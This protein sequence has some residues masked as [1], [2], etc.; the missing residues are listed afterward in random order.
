EGYLDALW[1]KTPTERHDLL[2][3]RAVSERGAGDVHH[4][5][6]E[7]LKS[8]DCFGV[9]V[10][11]RSGRKSDVV[12]EVAAAVVVVADEGRAGRCLGHARNPIAVN[13][14]LDQAVDDDEAKSVVTDC[15]DKNA[16]GAHLR[17]LIDEDAGHPG[18]K[19][20]A[21]G[22]CAAMAPVLALADELNQEL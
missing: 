14:M 20:S 1:L 6:P 5:E 13:S 10:E 18:R 16:I 12:D 9:C 11:L 8:C 22:V 15:S 2:A 17:G 21:I 4:V 3:H 19:R 7:L